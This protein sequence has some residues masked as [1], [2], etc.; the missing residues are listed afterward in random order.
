MPPPH[1]NSDSPLRYGLPPI[2]AP[3][4]VVGALVVIGAAFAAD[5]PGRIA[6]GVAGLLLLLGAGWASRGPTVTADSARITVRG[7][8]AR[9]QVPWSDVVAIRTDDRR[10]TRGV[11]IET[12]QTLVVVGATLLGRT[13]AVTVA[14][15]LRVR[16][17]TAANQP[18]AAPPGD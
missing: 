12:T 8:L 7:L 17:S 11:E 6:G 10:R 2:A 16:W 3:A 4:L 18:E 1:P 14:D 15:E 9:R 13:P 5:T